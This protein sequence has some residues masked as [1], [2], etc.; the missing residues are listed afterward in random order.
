MNAKPNTSLKSVRPGTRKA[1]VLPL[2]SSTTARAL[3]KAEA[4]ATLKKAQIQ[5]VRSVRKSQSALEGVGFF[6]KDNLKYI[7]SV[8]L[9]ISDIV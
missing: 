8:D 5:K 2:L 9:S 1:P 4:T 6:I 3:A 7:K